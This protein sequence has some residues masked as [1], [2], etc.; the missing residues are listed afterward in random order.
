M[1]M[2][3]KMAGIKLAVIHYSGSGPALTDLMAGHIQLMFT[4]VSTAVPLV[5]DGKIKLLG[6][7]SPKRFPQLPDVPTIAESGLPAFNARTWFAIYAPASVPRGRRA[8]IRSRGKAK[9]NGRH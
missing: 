3:Q 8:A 9:S 4:N 7:G 1:E 2:F 5:M 6:V